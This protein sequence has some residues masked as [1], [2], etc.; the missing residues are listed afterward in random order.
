MLRVLSH[1]A[2]QFWR[3]EE[4]L[5]VRKSDIDFD[6]KCVSFTQTKNRRVR[7]MPLTNETLKLV[8]ELIEEIEEFDTEY[9]L[10]FLG[11]D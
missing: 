8:E 3:I 5:S 4:V 9:L 10:M 6:R 7:I 11:T 1:D 2:R